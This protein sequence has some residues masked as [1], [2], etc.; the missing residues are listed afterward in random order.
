MAAR[1]REKQISAIRRMLNLNVSVPANANA[2]ALE[3]VWKV[4]IY[5]R[6]GQDI[7]FPL[8][9]VKD[10]RD[11]GVTL[12]LLLHSDREPIPDVPALYF[13]LPTEEN[14]Q[15]ICQD[16]QHGVY[17]SYFFNFISPI[18]RQRLED[19]AA[20]AL[21]GNCVTQVRKKLWNPDHLNVNT[22]LLL[23]VTAICGLDVTCRSVL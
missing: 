21:A 6:A 18:S 14:V 7:V 2:A 20:A 11:L 12:H 22:L 8:L 13:M 17:E 4:L 16:L 23:V 9:G 19:I 3:P 5:D 15:R 1:I 10:L